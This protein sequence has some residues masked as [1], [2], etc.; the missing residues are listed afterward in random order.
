MSREE[1]KHLDGNELK[2][3]LVTAQN[4]AYP[5]LKETF[6]LDTDASGLGVRA[7]QSQV[8]DRRQRV[9]ANGSWNASQIGG[10][11]CVTCW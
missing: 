6:I 7:V 10:I 1:N 9:I 4:L 2:R 3:R 11:Y 5:E 8:E